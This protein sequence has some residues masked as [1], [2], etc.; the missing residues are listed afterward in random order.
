METRRT[1]VR[2]QR[3]DVGCQTEMID[4]RRQTSDS[5]SPTSDP[6]TLISDLRLLLPGLRSL[7]LGAASLFLVGLLFG[8]VL[9]VDGDVTFKRKGGEGGT[10]PAMFPHWIHRIRYK[11]YA[12]HPALFEMKAGGGTVSMDL[13]QQG[14]SCGVCHNDQIAW[15]AS[16]ETC[17]RC[18]P[19]S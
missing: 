12:C 6:W 4:D 14:K 11:C 9:A 19:G 10:P 17:A 15:G 8:V 2:R 1:E 18:H 13:I 5:R 3:S 7:L 16:F